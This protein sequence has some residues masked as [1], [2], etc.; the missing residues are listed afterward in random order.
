MALQFPPFLGGGGAG[1][2]EGKHR[3][4]VWEVVSIFSAAE[5]ISRELPNCLYTFLC[6][7]C[8]APVFNCIFR[9]EDPPTWG[10]Q[11]WP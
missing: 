11:A 10:L 4:G 2:L 6:V 1:E 9:S 3:I 8:W 5:R 7:V